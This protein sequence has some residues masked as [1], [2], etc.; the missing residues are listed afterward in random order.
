[1][2]I[3][4]VSEIEWA[5]INAFGNTVSNFFAGIPAK[6]SCIYRR[7][8]MPDNDI[9]KEYYSITTKDCI[10]NWFS[11]GKIGKKFIY[12]KN[13]QTD[14]SKA[15]TST[16]FEKKIINFIHKFNIPFIARLDNALFCLGAWDN[17][18][19]K[20]YIKD[21]NPDIVF[22]FIRADK[23]FTMLLNAIKRHAPNCKIVASVVD[24]IYG[25][26]NNT[27]RKEI[28]KQ[29]ALCDH[30]YGASE[31]LCSVYGKIFNRKFTPL[32]KGCT[33]DCSVAEKKNEKLKIVYAGNLYYKRKDT[34]SA[35]AKAIQK[36]NLSHHKKLELEIYTPTE[37][38]KKTKSQLDIVGVS[39]LHFVKKYSEI[40]DILSKADVALHV[41]SFD[42]KQIQ[43]VKHSFSSKI[44]DCLQSGSV[45]M[46]IGPS[47]TA[48]IKYIMNVPGSVTVTDIS[49]L[50]KNIEKLIAEDLYEKAKLTR[51]FAVQN[52]SADEVYDKLFNDFNGIINNNI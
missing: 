17:N 37:V 5:D 50:E 14:K 27:N 20:E 9:C 18:K 36:H 44:M 35:L 16:T 25:I 23:S 1:M 28:E 26:A 47:Q 7:S 52:H 10:L 21:F 29:I 40:K 39:S 38:S 45:V 49:E 22:L 48:S 51:A 11:K 31:E 32:Y 3:L 43:I 30:L 24:D 46:A 6:F 13:S 15:G 19:F 41:E 8:S 34:L 4:V 2:N 12:D 42:P 33:F